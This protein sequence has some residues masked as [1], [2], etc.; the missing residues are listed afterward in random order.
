MTL[1]LRLY[2]INHTSV[3]GRARVF[4]P[5]FSAF[6]KPLVMNYILFRMFVYCFRQERVFTYFLYFEGKLIPRNFALKL[7]FTC[8]AGYYAIKVAGTD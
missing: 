8:L 2:E 6:F 5:N 4:V 1:S 3:E 7:H